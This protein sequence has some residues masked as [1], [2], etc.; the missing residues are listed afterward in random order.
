[1]AEQA[2]PTQSPTISNAENPTPAGLDELIAQ[3][4]KIF[5]ERQGESRRMAARADRVLAGRV[6]EN[7]HAIARLHEVGDDVRA[8]ETRSAGD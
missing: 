6:V 4:E 3:Q 5:V 2:V 7:G 8:D 1:M